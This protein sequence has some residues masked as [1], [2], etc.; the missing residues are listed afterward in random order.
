MS[1]ALQLAFVVGHRCH[2]CHNLCLLLL[3]VTPCIA[4]THNMHI[5]ELGGGFGGQSIALA[6]LT[7]GG[8]QSYT[9]I[10]LAESCLLATKN[11]KLTAEL[12][13]ASSRER[14]A[15]RRFSCVTSQEW[16]AAAAAAVAADGAADAAACDLFISN[17]A[18]SEL[19]AAVQA[20]I[21]RDVV[22]LCKRGH[23]QA[24]DI[25]S[26][27]GLVGSSTAE[28]VQGLRGA[29]LQP[30]LRSEYLNQKVLP[31][32]IIEWGCDTE[33]CDENFE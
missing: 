1:A 17:F 25:S 21:I 29:G 11:M 14:Q 22:S 31:V 10:D 6:S 16:S 30:V 2:L 9:D 12:P 13:F 7:S 5:V 24:N 20:H 18:L 23:I 4:A 27:H 19:S 32:T 28:L 15:L 3:F 8:F 33:G 26:H